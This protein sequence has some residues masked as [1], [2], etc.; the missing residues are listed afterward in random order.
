MPC[1]NCDR[2]QCEGYCL[3][4]IKVVG[5][6]GSTGSTGPQGRDGT[7]CDTGATGPV[8]SVGPTGS[9]GSS[10]VTGSTG[11]SGQTG[12]TGPTGPTGDIG[13]TGSLE[14]PVECVT[15]SNL[16]DKI[17]T[18]V[19]SIVDFTR[20]YSPEN[21]SSPGPT[22]PG[23]TG[24]CC[25]TFTGR[26]ELT[27]NTTPV[28]PNTSIFVD[29]VPC[30]SSI[31]F[32]YCYEGSNT[33]AIF[34]IKVI[35]NGVVN[36]VNLAGGSTSETCDTILAES[37]DAGARFGFFIN[38]TAGTATAKITN[39]RVEYEE[40]CCDIVGIKLGDLGLCE[41]IQMT[42]E[43]P[44]V[45]TQSRP[46]LFTKIGKIVTAKFPKT[47]V[48]NNSDDFI[49]GQ[50]IPDKYRPDIYNA[51]YIVRVFDDSEY[52][53]GL[54]VVLTDGTVQIYA[55]LNNDIFESVDQM[56]GFEAVTLTWIGT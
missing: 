27:I 55:G 34:G 31:T 49:T 11:S 45:E 14:C 6:T 3:K 28:C 43:G 44:F 23:P 39:F 54:F 25:P 5:P 16:D 53:S 1:N 35:R 41:T 32:M 22:G 51:E 48:P 8:G 20:Q 13:P 46:V 50:L 26:T 9:T 52:K 12:P 7:A 4:I 10:G 15:G 18:E 47:I 24:P 42:F 21:W 2:V 17:I 56:A 33:D 19:K 38:S 29:V 40:P 36:T 37:I 30:K